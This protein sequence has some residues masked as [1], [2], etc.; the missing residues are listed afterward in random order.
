MHDISDISDDD[1]RANVDS[2]SR[3]VRGIVSPA[4]R[5]AN[6]SSCLTWASP[7]LIYYICIV[8]CKK[9]ACSEPAQRSGQGASSMWSG[10]LCL[11]IL[12][13]LTYHMG[14]CPPSLKS[15]PLCILTILTIWDSF[16]HYAY[17]P[18]LL[19]IWECVLLA[20]RVVHYAYLPYLRTIW[21][22]FHQLSP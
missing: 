12:T 18:Y 2:I 19:T 5:F 17:L 7:T 1:R 3:E 15:G 6:F 14:M 16:L 21:D 10:P 11:C 22:S 9:S 8:R 13:I 20:Y 4:N